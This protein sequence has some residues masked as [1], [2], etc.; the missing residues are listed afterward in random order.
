MPYYHRFASSMPLRI[1]E[2][3][4]P[5]KIRDGAA[6]CEL[7]APIAALGYSYGKLI[8]NA[9][10]D[11]KSDPTL[12][13]KPATTL[14]AECFQFI[15]PDDLLVLSTRPPINDLTSG[16]KKRVTMSCTDLEDK[17]FAAC[18]RYI[19]I[20]NRSLII[21]QSSVAAN[22]E[23]AYMVFR[24]YKSARLQYYRTLTGS[25]RI[26]PPRETN[27]SIGF[28]LYVKE[29]PQYGCGLVAS[30]GMGGWETLIWNRI[31]RTQFPAWFRDPIFV[32]AEI[33]ISEFPHNFATLDFVDQIKPKILLEHPIR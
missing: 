29:I 18:N 7:A 21:L 14:G 1:G 17:V 30:F 16:D 12:D 13:V 15:K 2:T 10:I 31:V 11:L 4:T 8:F 5:Y 20:C 19:K 24:Q 26:K 28:F 25:A 32:V 9:P 33:T 3:P 27:P 22:F 6:F 23:R